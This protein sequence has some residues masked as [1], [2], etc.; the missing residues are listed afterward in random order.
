MNRF[1]EIADRHGIATMFILF[2]DC[3]LPIA[4]R[5]SARRQNQFPV[6]TTASG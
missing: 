5:G 1:L 4:T 2:D 3:N 6:C